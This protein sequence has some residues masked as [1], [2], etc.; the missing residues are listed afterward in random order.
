M[1]EA[2]ILA[3]GLGTRLYP[4][5]LTVP[6]PM[7]PVS[8][9]PFLEYLLNRLLEHGF[10]RVI[11]SVGYLG[12][13]IESYFGKS[14]QGL[15]LIYAYEESP[16][17]TGGAIALALSY[18]QTEHVLVL[19]GDTFCA[20]DWHGMEAFH[21]NKKAD[22]TIALKPMTNFD[23]YGNVEVDSER[24]VSFDEKQ[25]VISGQINTGV[26]ILNKTLFKTFS[27]PEKFS[28]EVDFLQCKLTEVLVA[29]FMTDSYFIDI[30][31]PE[32]YQR[33]QVELPSE[34]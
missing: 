17:G 15:E 25:H 5:T 24:I 20:L 11:L 10:S 1:K 21:N 28:F 30:G 16:L 8:D 31:I 9:K 4:L 19:N 14:W 27:M 18:A 12:K 13:Q 26:Y 34:I 3:G 2:V 6:K 22:L 33:A 29:A 7:V 32:D 23:R